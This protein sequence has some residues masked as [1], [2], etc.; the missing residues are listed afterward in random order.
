[1][2]VLS[3]LEIDNA[4]RENGL[5]TNRIWNRIRKQVKV[6]EMRRDKDGWGFEL[7][8]E[9]FKE[10]TKHEAKWYDKKIGDKVKLDIPTDEDDISKDK[11]SKDKN[12][13]SKNKNE[14]SK[15]KNTE[16]NK[17]LLLPA[18]THNST[19][20]Y[21]SEIADPFFRMD[22]KKRKKAYTSL[23]EKIAGKRTQMHVYN[24][25]KAS[26][27]YYYL[28]YRTASY[29]SK[30]GKRCPDYGTCARYVQNCF[31]E[32]E[33]KIHHAKT[34]SPEFIIYSFLQEIDQNMKDSI[35]LKISQTIAQIK[36]RKNK[37]VI[38][39]KLLEA[40]NTLKNQQKKGTEKKHD[41]FDESYADFLLAALCQ[42]KDADGKPYVERIVKVSNM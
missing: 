19:M 38:Q 20:R 35:T 31:H 42:A 1:L 28:S 17:V 2:E 39:K 11:A 40:Y 21:I 6:Y 13:N 18:G 36:K 7:K 25:I 15:D 41:Y 33:D 5:N 12:K 29:I 24:D 30:D 23:V 3:N 37:S 27:A 8:P 22:E 32:I 26:A 16:E 34:T 9:Y 10:M 4:K 14:T